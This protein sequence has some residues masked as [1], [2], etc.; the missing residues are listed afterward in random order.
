MYIYK[1][2]NRDRGL[3]DLL[4]LFRILS[5]VL[6]V[7]EKRPQKCPPGRPLTLNAQLLQKNPTFVAS[8][9]TIANQLE[10]P[11]NFS[12]QDHLNSDSVREW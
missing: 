9:A 7:L 11:T 6:S 2:E 4:P 10:N 12:S 8:T 5:A 3:A 1:S